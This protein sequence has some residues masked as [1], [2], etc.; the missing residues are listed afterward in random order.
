MS[1]VNP[2]LSSQ[3]QYIQSPMDTT[4]LTSNDS[5]NIYKE[6]SCPK[7]VKLNVVEKYRNQ[8]KA[9]SLYL[10]PPQFR[11]KTKAL[12]PEKTKKGKKTRKDY[13]GTVINK[14][15]K[16]NVK[17]VFIDEISDQPLI[18][19]VPIESIKEFNIVPFAEGGKD[20]YVKENLCC[21]CFVF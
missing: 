8:V 10:V 17:L 19:D 5:K 9:P 16:K 4:P 21:S 11:Q 15:N 12:A 3:D 13:F 6:V 7:V 20:C 18:E 14:K 2:V 1:A